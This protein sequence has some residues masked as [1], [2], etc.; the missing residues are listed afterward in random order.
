MIEIVIQLQTSVIF[1]HLAGGKPTVYKYD[2]AKGT[3]YQLIGKK[4]IFVHE[5]ADGVVTYQEYRQNILS[6]NA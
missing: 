4:W 5:D 3:F 6:G 2:T 1:R